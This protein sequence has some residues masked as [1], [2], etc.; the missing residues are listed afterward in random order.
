MLNINTIHTYLQI[1]QNSREPLEVFRE[2]I[3]NAY[4]NGASEIEVTVEYIQE[5]ETIN[6]TFK[7]NGTGLSKK[8]IEELIFGLGHSTKINDDNY[9]GN[10][11]VGTLL[12]LKSRSVTVTSFIDGKGAKQRWIEP[13]R[14]LLHYRD[15]FNTDN[16][17]IG[18]QEPEDVLCSDQENGTTIEIN[19][20]LHNN[21]LE[22]HQENLTD[23]I[24]WFTKLAS[25][26]NQLHSD[27]IRQ[28]NVKLKGLLFTEYN[29]DSPLLNPY[30]TGNESY[31]DISEIK[32]KDDADIISIGFS[33]PSVSDYEELVKCD[34]LIEC[35]TDNIIK[36]IKKL[37]VLKFSSNDPL[38]SEFELD[39][40]YKDSLG[41]LKDAKVEFV[42]YRIGESI[43]T[44]HNKMLKRSTNSL[45]SYKYLVSERHGIYLSKNYIPI[46]QINSI[47][48]SI[49]GGG[50]GKWQYVGFFNCESIDLTIDRT[51]AATI[52]GDLQV[53]LIKKINKLMVTIDKKVNE[54]IDDLVEKVNALRAER[55]QTIDN[56]NVTEGNKN[57][58]DIQE[59]DDGDTENTDE[60]TEDTEDSEEDDGNNEDSNDTGRNFTTEAEKLEIQQ[61]KA[62]KTQR[63]HK[64]KL[65]KALTVTTT[66][67]D[68]TLREPNSESELYGI[69]MQIISLR[70][71]LFDFNI[72]D[73]NT[74]NGI[75][76]LARDKDESE[77]NFDNLFHIE[78]KERLTNR[79][80]HLLDDVKYIICWTIDDSLRRFLLLRDKYQYQYRLDSQ[81]GYYILKREN[82][83][84]IVKI[85]ELKDLI[86]NH[87]GQFNVARG[88]VMR[89]G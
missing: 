29:D 59:N 3:A 54:E 14:T 58:D 31:I 32:T 42:V 63:I 78:L 30:D 7:D 60:D 5:D 41:N 57:D 49:G 66:E 6:L 25:F 86:E 82:P 83:V 4:D 38:F 13:Y 68:I 48:Q 22:Y 43:R 17:D 16:I 50:N 72:L 45:P 21:P 35:K 20:F 26:E 1:V 75:D 51:G 40:V 70:P 56:D 67:G 64:I 65:K 47:I 9:I 18:I 87:F 28:F 2:A 61:K 77:D 39:F 76:I 15:S 36:E 62:R 37:L 34:K 85:I 89:R 81:K 24:L 69:L 53:K 55:E 33:F 46:Q 73:Y 23:F 74:S 80:N 19:G 27:E 8:N 12:F 84:N 52:N 79:M 10:K 71:D 44:E 88:S 11:G